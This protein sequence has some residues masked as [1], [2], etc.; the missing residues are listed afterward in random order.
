MNVAHA[1]R[2]TAAEA[3]RLARHLYGLSLAAEPQRSGRDRNSL[4]EVVFQ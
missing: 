2:F 1:P 3:A 4:V